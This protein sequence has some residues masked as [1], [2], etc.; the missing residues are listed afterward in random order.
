META[1]RAK[2]LHK[3]PAAN[4]R[5]HTIAFALARIVLDLH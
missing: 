3:P 5:I 4:N 2:E 1:P